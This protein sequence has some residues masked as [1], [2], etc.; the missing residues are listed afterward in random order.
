MPVDPTGEIGDLLDAITWMGPVPTVVCVVFAAFRSGLSARGPE[1][2]SGQG[3]VAIHC[4]KAGL[5]AL[6]RAGRRGTRCQ[7]GIHS[8][9]GAVVPG[10]VQK[11]A[12]I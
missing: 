6:S 8:P 9:P 11:K 3:L 7:S 10:L 1:A 4:G 12:A 5:R 2:I